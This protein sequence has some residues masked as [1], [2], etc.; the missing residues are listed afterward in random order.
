MFFEVLADSKIMPSWCEDLSKCTLEEVF[1]LRNENRTL[2]KSIRLRTAALVNRRLAK[3]ISHE[4]YVLNRKLAHDDE[5]E[6]RRRAMMLADEID[7]RLH[8]S[9]LQSKSSSESQEQS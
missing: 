1:E 3:H 9:L 8:R 2:N 7:R 6:C 5:G 4:E